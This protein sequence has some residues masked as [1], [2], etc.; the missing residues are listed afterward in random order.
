MNSFMK[1]DPLFSY[2]D[3]VILLEII[4]L[5][6]EK[7]LNIK[8]GGSM[9]ALKISMVVMTPQIFVTLISK[10]IHNILA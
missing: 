5:S 6:L 9:F 4:Q 8:L 3:K 10:F 2:C 1:D 7:T